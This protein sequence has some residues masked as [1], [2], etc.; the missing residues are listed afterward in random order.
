MIF[1]AAQAANR[2]SPRSSGKKIFANIPPLV[3]RERLSK[4][5]DCFFRTPRN[6]WRQF[7][8]PRA[9]MARGEDYGGNH[10]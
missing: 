5:G 6:Y 4:H 7:A 2:L 10:E 3:V 8:A 9:G 1:E